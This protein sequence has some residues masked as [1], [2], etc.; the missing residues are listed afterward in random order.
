MLQKYENFKN[1]ISLKS[2]SR[3]L[4]QYGNVENW[5]SV[6]KS[7]ME[8][9]INL[10]EDNYSSE[11]TFYKVQLTN[12]LE[13]LNTIIGVRYDDYILSAAL[14][15]G[16]DLPYS[17]QAGQCSSCL[18]KLWSGQVDQADQSFLF[19]DEIAANWV[20]TCVAI[21]LSDCTIETHQEENL[22]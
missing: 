14:E 6:L 22:Y 8:K 15:A 4:S 2:Q 3:I 10:R 12:Q 5:Y 7:K 16:I 20:L 18:G 21:P 9:K 19:D 17:C 13:G 1:K 11:F